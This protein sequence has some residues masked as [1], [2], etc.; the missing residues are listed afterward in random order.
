[1]RTLLILTCR[2]DMHLTRSMLRRITRLRGW[3]Y[4]SHLHLHLD[5]D[6][7]LAVAEATLLSATPLPE[8]H[9]LISQTE[10]PDGWRTDRARTML[11]IYQRACKYNQDIVRLDPDVYIASPDFFQLLARP[12]SGIA[13]KLMPLYLPATVK[14]RPLDFVQGGVSLWG[15]KGRRY[16]RELDVS[17]I[18]QFKTS[19]LNVV[20]LGDPGRQQEYEYFFRTTEDVVLTGALA[21]VAGIERTNIPGIQVSSYD[22]MR[23]YRSESWT[24]ADF[25]ESYVRSGASA[26]HFEGAHDGRRE[27][28][29]EMLRQ[30]YRAQDGE[31]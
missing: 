12:Y 25:I 31:E 30:F 19:Y 28:M 8:E 18:Q 10:Q 15:P 4:F 6:V 29:S 21:M 20:N 17:A 16:L 26:Y 7:P 14:G 22:V 23:D 11:G 1:M 2:H 27:K 9:V 24:Y 5:N 13:G 3:Q